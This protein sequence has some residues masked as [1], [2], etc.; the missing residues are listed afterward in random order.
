MLGN[1]GKRIESR[2]DPEKQGSQLALSLHPE[3]SLELLDDDDDVVGSKRSRA[4]GW[5]EEEHPVVCETIV[6]HDEDELERSDVF[7][8]GVDDRVEVGS[9]VDD[10]SFGT[11]R[12]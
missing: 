7:E 4:S 12:T 8:D 5:S 10:H 3:R 11:K 6:W 2:G 9:V 1:D